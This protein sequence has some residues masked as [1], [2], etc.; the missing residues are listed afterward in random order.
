MAVIVYELRA[1]VLSRVDRPWRTAVHDGLAREAGEDIAY[2]QAMQDAAAGEAEY[3]A[4]RLRGTTAEYVPAPFAAPS[5]WRAY[6]QAACLPILQEAL[7][8]PEPARSAALLP[9]NEEASRLMA[10]FRPALPPDR[11]PVR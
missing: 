9:A 4:V 1:G 8:L 3:F 11:A 6:W 7:A 5:P 10:A 2:A